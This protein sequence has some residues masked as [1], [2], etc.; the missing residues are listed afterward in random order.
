MTIN[1]GNGAWNNS[2][3]NFNHGNSKV[4][5]TNTAATITGTTDFY[6][7]TINT[8]ATLSMSN[9]SRIGIGGNLI[10]NGILNTIN[11]GISTVEYNGGSQTV[12]VPNPSSNRYYNLI[13]SGSGT[14]AMPS[15]ALEI[16]GDIALSGSA[17]TSVNGPM[18][19]DGNFTI[20]NGCSFLVPPAKNLT[21]SGTF[22]NN[23]GTAGL[24][25]GSDATGTGSLI[26][27]TPGVSAT[28]KR[29]MTKDRWHIISSPV[30][31]Q[32]IPVF[33]TD[34]SNTIPTSGNNYGMMY[35]AEQTGGWVYYTNP[36]TGSL[37]VGT[38]YLLRHTTDAAV[39]IYGSLN[40]ATTDV[41]LTRLG[42]GWNSVG[43]PFPCSIAV[44]SD[45][46]NTSDNFLTYN[47]AQF[48]PS[49][50]VLYLWDEP[51]VRVTGVNYYKVIGNSGFTSALPIIDQAYL[52]PGQGF[53]VKSNAAGGTMHFTTGMRVHENTASFFKSLKASWPG[54]NLIV[55]S[56]TKSASTAVA[57]QEDMTLGLDV[58]FDAGLLG[59]DPSFRIYTRLVE[60]NGV[61]FML[62]CLPYDDFDNICVPI[63]F[64]CP[65]GGTVTF[66]SDI[67]PLPS[68]LKAILADSLLG[69][70][71]D[72][73][74]PSASYTT[75]VNPNSSGT[76]RFFLNISGTTTYVNK[77]AD[78]NRL[79]IYAVRK[80]IIVSGK[81]SPGSRADLY[82]ISG[83]VIRNFRFNST[84]INI[85][86]ADGINSG[87]YILKIT[88][89]GVNQNN[90]VVLK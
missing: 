17:S 43:N 15:T 86:K 4:L 20:G 36:A 72:L 29:Y 19:V 6:D 71:T 75:F 66:T 41:P 48:D 47:S 79:D 83:R 5:F 58:T 8:G 12:T 77:P 63:G 28:F 55:S 76:G 14:K 52:Q 49:Y 24:V 35:Y 74:E 61:N 51:A 18:L 54:I 39:S 11:E 45:A 81:V 90:K 32:S 70:F 65:D 85:L 62:Q 57:F 3:G 64:D 34:L 33:L 59:G 27:S 42:N 23:A 88:G 38:G 73:Q 10:I 87:V 69:K 26:N 67:V 25:I 16:L 37:S 13:L 89:E 46:T 22:T 68:G 1:G 7:L 78:R 84:D 60:D 50:A 80:E 31:G 44:R 53:L 82:D 30:S 2:G 21:V 56:P 40:A 9:Q